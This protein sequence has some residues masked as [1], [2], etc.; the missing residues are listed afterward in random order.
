METQ[1]LTAALFGVTCEHLGPHQHPVPAEATVTRQPGSSTWSSGRLLRPFPPGAEVLEGPP[2][3][4]PSA[5]DLHR[6]QHPRISELVQDQ[7]LVELVRH[8]QTG[9]GSDT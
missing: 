7:R 6:L 4:E 2:H 3:W 8:L 1:Q 5:S 9:N